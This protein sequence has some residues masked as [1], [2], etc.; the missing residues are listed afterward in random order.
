MSPSESLH[1][2]YM[3]LLGP[4]GKCRRQTDERTNVQRADRSST[5]HNM[6]EAEE[7]KKRLSLRVLLQQSFF[8]SPGHTSLTIFFLLK[9]NDARSLAHSIAV[10]FPLAAAAEGRRRRCSRKPELLRAN[11]NKLCSNWLTR[12]TYVSSP[13]VYT[14]EGANSEINLWEAGDS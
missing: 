3:A 10:E 11:R 7:R 14:P 2:T 6:A 12:C 13:Y 1:Y 9:T 4:T 8:F 5:M